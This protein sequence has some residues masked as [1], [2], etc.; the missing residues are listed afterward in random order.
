MGAA[1]RGRHYWWS[2]LWKIDNP[3]GKWWEFLRAFVD[4]EEEE[5]ELR[6]RQRREQMVLDTSVQDP[7]KGARKAEPNEEEEK[8]PLREESIKRKSEEIETHTG[9]GSGGDNEFNGCTSKSGFDKEL[10]KEAKDEQQ[11]SFKYTVE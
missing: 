2:V 7:G 11:P 4:K 10:Q 5:K 8:E 1:L 9:S 6:E 3:T